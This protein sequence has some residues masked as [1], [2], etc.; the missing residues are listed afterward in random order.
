[1]NARSAPKDAV[2][3]EIVGY[4]Q[5]YVDRHLPVL[6]IACDRGHFIRWVAGS[7]RWASDIRDVESQ[8][9]ADVQFIKGS[10]CTSRACCPPAT[11]GPCS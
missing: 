11:S 6:D 5:R 9:P 2:W 7:E 8:L 4:L 3:R 10:A 1:M